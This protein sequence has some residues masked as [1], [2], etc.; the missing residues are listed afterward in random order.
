MAAK[1]E[2]TF[3]GHNLRFSSQRI[4]ASPIEVTDTATLVQEKHGRAQVSACVI[5][6]LE[7]RERNP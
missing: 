1:E 4:G 2:E 6:A 3:G 5:I 7:V